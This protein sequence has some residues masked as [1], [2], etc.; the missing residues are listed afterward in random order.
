[1]EKGCERERGRE[2]ETETEAET[3]TETERSRATARER[4]RE[5][6]RERA[7]EKERE[8]ESERTRCEGDERITGHSLV[9]WICGLTVYRAVEGFLKTAAMRPP[10]STLWTQSTTHA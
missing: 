3:E 2:T 9:A 1:M 10:C 8:R 7:R 6:D 4:E 5:R